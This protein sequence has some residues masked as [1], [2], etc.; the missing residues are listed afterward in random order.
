[1]AAHGLASGD[2]D[3]Q[4]DFSSRDELGQMA[5][6]VR[7]MI[8][9]QQTISGVAENVAV[10]DLRVNVT[11]ASDRDVL[12][13]A[14]NEMVGRLG[15]LLSETRSSADD[16][17]DTSALLDSV[18][19]EA[20][21]TVREVSDSVQRA[22]DDARGQAESMAATSRSVDQLLQAIE[23]VA[24][25]A[26]EQARDLTS[27]SIQ[28]EEMA[29]GVE[30]VADVARTVAE[31]GRAS[32]ET[33]ERGAAAVREA[34]AGMAAIEHVVEEAAARVSGLSSLG[35]RI[36]AVVET[37]NEIAEQTNLL[38]LNAAIEAARAGEH[39]KGFAVVADE[40]RK[41]AERSQRE[42]RAIGDLIQAVQVG[43][44]DAVRAMESGAERVRAGARQ[45]DDAGQALGE[46]LAAV[47]RT[48]SEVDGIAEASHEVM[49]HGRAVSDALVRLSAVV[50]ESSAAAEEMTATADD[51]GRSV[52]DVSNVAGASTLEL[53]GVAASAERMHE[54]MATIE[55]R[56][57]QLASTAAGLRALVARFQL[58]DGAADPTPTPVASADR[59]RRSAGRAAPERL[60]G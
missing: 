40:V 54:Q 48:V 1:M 30:R 46:I 57:D 22:A 55:S 7:E 51:V 41:L 42:T 28:A 17:A 32:R 16:V 37:I 15:E 33:A 9:Y 3:Q 8:A 53:D 20:A 47:E 52:Q 44:E 10:G 31:S 29:T 50:E 34:V 60:A 58:D 24:R 25:G 6:A 18:T 23:Q 2:L 39:G 5:T 11:P 56:A 59:A 36:G 12:G 19:R 35:S 27:A 38:A 14:V 26:Q 21:A 45:A 49:A 13:T 4:V 43:T